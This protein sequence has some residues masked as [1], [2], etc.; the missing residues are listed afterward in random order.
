M[1]RKANLYAHVNGFYSYETPSTSTAYTESTP[2][3]SN[4]AV[5][6]LSKESD[7]YMVNLN[8]HQEA[9]VYLQNKI[10]SGKRTLNSNVETTKNSQSNEMYYNDIHGF[11]LSTSTTPL[12]VT[13]STS[14]AAVQ[15]NL[16]ENAPSIQGLNGCSENVL[17]LRTNF[18][19][20][21]NVVKVKC[22]ISGNSESNEPEY[23]DVP[24]ALLPGTSRCSEIAPFMSNEA[25]QPGFSGTMPFT[26]GLNKYV[27]NPGD[28]HIN[29]LNGMSRNSYQ[30]ISKSYRSPTDLFYDSDFDSDELEDD[31]EDLSKLFEST[32][33]TSPVLRRAITNDAGRFLLR[34]TVPHAT[35]HFGN[36]ENKHQIDSQNASSN[37][38]FSL[39]SKLHDPVSFQPNKIFCANPFPSASSIFPSLTTCFASDETN[40]TFPVET[41]P[42]V[43]DLNKDYMYLAESRNIPGNMQNLL[44]PIKDVIQSS[45]PNEHN[46][47][48]FPSSTAMSAA[49]TSVPSR[50]ANQ[51][52]H[53]FKTEKEKL[54]ENVKEFDYSMDFQN[55]SKNRNLQSNKIDWHK[56]YEFRPSNTSTAVPGL[57][58]NIRHETAQTTTM[59]QTPL[60]T[61]VGR[62]VEDKYVT[63]LK[64]GAVDY[65]LNW[66]RE[67]SGNPETNEMQQQNPYEFPPGN[68]IVFPQI[69]V[70][71]TIVKSPLKKVIVMKNR[72]EYPNNN[73]QEDLH[74][75]MAKKKY[76]IKSNQRF[77]MHREPK[78]V[79]RLRAKY[80]THTLAKRMRTLL[81]KVRISQLLFPSVY[82][83]LS[84][85]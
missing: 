40:Q 60:A 30:R 70:M 11:H 47:V 45:R 39:K 71:D 17:D 53:I 67:A 10:A 31:G 22:E 79:H 12:G 44:M 42:T 58:P 14:N 23:G 37:G 76:F 36:L 32:S 41:A 8:L 27:K 19:N 15:Q 66:V 80:R 6:N 28:R 73:N 74:N 83:M 69:M 61:N 49:F 1:E 29:V 82:R 55:N 75:N 50:E 33:T 34:K 48:I 57:I 81:E 18:T 63:N 46:P 56:T 24:S 9:P 85:Q 20:E 38:K 13:S 65:F 72:N 78:D 5:Q 21:K 2:I 4:N 77:D 68:S 51:K 26:T 3:I 64:F 43:G 62:G 59:K 7:P 25:A 84:I 35:N 52:N 54:L 16:M